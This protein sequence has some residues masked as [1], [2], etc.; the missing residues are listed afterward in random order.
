[1]STDP[2]AT[3]IVEQLISEGNIDILE[4]LMRDDFMRDL[5]R[6]LEVECS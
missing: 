3:E 5:D 4:M 2:R 6:D 1:M